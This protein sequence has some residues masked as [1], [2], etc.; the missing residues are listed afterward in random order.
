M[1]FLMDIC[2][3]IPTKLERD[4]VLQTPGVVKFI[5]HDQKDAVVPEKQ[6]ES[7]IREFVELGYNISEV[8]RN[9]TFRSG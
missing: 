1:P 6:I 2:L 7:L 9:E 4:I 8:D 5:R 3:F